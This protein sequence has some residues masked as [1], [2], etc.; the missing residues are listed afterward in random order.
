MVLC[1]NKEYP[2]THHS[3]QSRWVWVCLCVC[4][5]VCVCVKL[6]Q[7][8]LRRIKERYGSNLAMMLE[9]A[10]CVIES[11]CVRR[12]AMPAH[13]QMR[14]RFIQRNNGQIHQFHKLCWCTAWF[15]RKSLSGLGSLIG[16]QRG[17]Q[18]DD[19]SLSMDFERLLSCKIGRVQMHVFFTRPSTK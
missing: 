1:P 12:P 6:C 10:W 16:G 15:V 17:A 2:N 5:Y 8:F 19:G 3:A 11:R 7:A 4:V 9:A 18:M 14:F 13:V